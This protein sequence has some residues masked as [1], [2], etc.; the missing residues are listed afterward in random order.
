MLYICEAMLSPPV[1]KFPP[2]IV[3]RLVEFLEG[4]RHIRHYSNGERGVRVIFF[5]PPTPTRKK[6]IFGGDEDTRL[7]FRFTCTD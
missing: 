6:C 1:R 3:L 7:Q 5:L 4:E 2:A